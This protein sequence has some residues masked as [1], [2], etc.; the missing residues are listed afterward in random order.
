MTDSMILRQA[1]ID[2]AEHETA[3]KIRKLQMKRDSWEISDDEY[4]E[5][6]ESVMQDYRLK[7]LSLLPS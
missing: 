2:Q 6:Y 1:Y 7:V 5:K 4:E 3:E